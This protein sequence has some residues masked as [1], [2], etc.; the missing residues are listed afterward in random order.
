MN[1]PFNFF[2]RI[3]CINLKR[4]KDRWSKIQS[5]CR[6]IGISQ[7]IIRFDA[8]NKGKHRAWGCSLSHLKII[9]TA[10]KLNLKNVLVFEDDAFFHKWNPAYLKNAIENLPDDWGVF[11]LGYNFVNTFFSVESP[12]FERISENLIKMDGHQDV[13]GFH[14]VA[15]NNTIYDLFLE[16][17]DIETNWKPH[18][19]KTI[20]VWTP[21]YSG[22][23]FYCLIPLM[24]FQ[25]PIKKAKRYKRNYEKLSKEFFQ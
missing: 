24:S 21:L 2:D 25:N 15:Y 9:K 7:K 11:R 5:H 14:C 4:H 6:E 12:R 8:V 3:Y 22:L 23:D 10:K 18:S 20:D 17:Y 16:K 13:R 19:G 1:D